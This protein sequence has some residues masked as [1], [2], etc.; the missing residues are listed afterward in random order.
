M[1]GNLCETWLN[2]WHTWLAAAQDKRVQKTQER[3]RQTLDEQRVDR[4][5]FAEARAHP[6]ALLMLP[7]LSRF[8]L[9]S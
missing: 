8:A 6:H 7:L 9:C 3:L 1:H 4:E 2:V 5:V